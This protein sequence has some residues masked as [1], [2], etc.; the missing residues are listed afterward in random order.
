MYSEL[1]DF[2]LIIYIKN[3][4][5]WKK[6]ILAIYKKE[7]FQKFFWVDRRFHSVQRSVVVLWSA[8]EDGSKCVKTNYPLLTNTWT[9]FYPD[10]CLHSWSKPLQLWKWVGGLTFNCCVQK[11][12]WCRSANDLIQ[13]YFARTSV[14]LWAGNSPLRL[15]Y[16][17]DAHMSTWGAFSPTLLPPS[18]LLSPTLYALLSCLQLGLSTS[19]VTE[20]ASDWLPWSW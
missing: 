18:F 3:V 5:N 15:R 14:K 20:K 2:V 19:S 12:H 10:R 16:E 17:I 11:V 7:L 1:I 13:I 6:C 9:I 4:N 8:Q